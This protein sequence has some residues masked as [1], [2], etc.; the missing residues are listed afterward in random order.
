MTPTA[1]NDGD[2]LVDAPGI[3]AVRHLRALATTPGHPP[4]V[5]GRSGAQLTDQSTIKAASSP[6][7]LVLF[8]LVSYDSISSLQ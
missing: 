5:S 1:G 7:G 3:E 4:A 2:V 8:S 6:P